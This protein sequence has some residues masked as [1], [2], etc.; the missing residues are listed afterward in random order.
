M[1]FQF[2]LEALKGHKYNSQGRSAAQ[3]LAIIFMP[4][5]GFNQVNLC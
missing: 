1:R 3:P 5:W 4:S 2:Q